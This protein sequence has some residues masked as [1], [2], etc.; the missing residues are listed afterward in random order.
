MKVRP[1]KGFT[2]IE[3]LVVVAIIGLLSTVV[4]TSLDSA[5]AKARDARRLVDL[6]EVRTAL[7][8][9]RVE[10]G[11]FPISTTWRGV[12]AAFNPSGTITRTGANGWIPNLAPRFISVLPVEAKP[13]DNN[14][15]LY[16]STINGTGYIVIS[17]ASVETKVSAGTYI[18]TTPCTPTLG[19][20]NT[21]P[22][23]RPRYPAQATFAVYTPIP[24]ICDETFL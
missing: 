18:S 9:Y 5:R 16:R 8:N 12:C 10:N 15:Y 20:T 1:Q 2:L 22:A 4:L 23:N 19:A 11:A 14:C 24:T 3:I 17:H 6:R 21:N 13:T 7:E